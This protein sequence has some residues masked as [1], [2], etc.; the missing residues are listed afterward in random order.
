MH[1]PPEIIA[2]PRTDT[3]FAA[4]AKQLALRIPSDLPPPDALR[5]YQRA[6]RITYP[7]A[8]VREQDE[9]ARTESARYRVWYASNRPRPFRIA[10]TFTVPLPVDLAFEIYVDRVAEWQT[11]VRLRPID[12]SGGSPGATHGALGGR[13]WNATYRF[14]GI[15]YTGRLLIREADPPNAV[16][17]EASGSGIT[18]WY[19]TAFASR[20]P[21]ETVVAVR[22]DYDLPSSM[23]ARIADRLH[24]ER[25]VGRDIERANASYARLCAAEASVT[26]AR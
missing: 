25:T 26:P 23:L 16:T 10:T 24:L 20:G 17:Y 22:G 12:G 21:D 8:V 11:A 15:A 18:V 3:A 6:L 9:L 13:T 7:N 2:S 1:E 4:E 5:W 19:T 14:L